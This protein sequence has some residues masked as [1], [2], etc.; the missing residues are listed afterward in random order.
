M[1]KAGFF[2][3]AFEGDGI[4]PSAR[5]RLRPRGSF[6]KQILRAGGDLAAFARARAVTWPASMSF[7]SFAASFDSVIP[8]EKR[9]DTGGPDDSL[10]RRGASSSGVSRSGTTFF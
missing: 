10:E 5:P 9:S 1:S 2:G 8:E 4:L 3:Y 7:R 6:A